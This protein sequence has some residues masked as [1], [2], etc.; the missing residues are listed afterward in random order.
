MFTD[1]P[2]FELCL[3]HCLSKMSHHILYQA[4]IDALFQLAAHAHMQYQMPPI[5]KND[6]LVLVYVCAKFGA[7]IT[8]FTIGLLCHTTNVD[9]ASFYVVCKVKIFIV[10]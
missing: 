4:G 2:V 1:L 9:F 3:C 10:I 8:K 6:H 5:S 7:F